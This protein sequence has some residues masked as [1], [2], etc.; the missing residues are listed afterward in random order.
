MQS[1]QELY[2][3]IILDHNRHPRNYGKIGHYNHEAHGHNPLCG[4]QVTIYLC[5]NPQDVI[6]DITF[7]AKGCAISVASASLMTEK[8]K[9]TT[10]AEAKILFN[11]FHE[12]VTGKIE[13]DSLTN[14]ELEHLQ[15]LTALAGVREFP[16]RV[17]CATMAWHTFLSALESPALEVSHKPD[18]KKDAGSNG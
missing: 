5:L 6:E 14:E 16:M 7:K 12:L 10:A 18:H 13:E 4:D 2:Q 17:K 9:G 8:L 3:Q 11:Q 15:P 1:L